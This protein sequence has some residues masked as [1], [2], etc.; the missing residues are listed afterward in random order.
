[1]VDGGGVLILKGKERHGWSGNNGNNS[2]LSTLFILR[3]I[4]IFRPRVIV[5]MSHQQPLPFLLGVLV[6]LLLGG[7]LG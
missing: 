3:V 5:F 1:V 6:P 2:H 4:I 7:E